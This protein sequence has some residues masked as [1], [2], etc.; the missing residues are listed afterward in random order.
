MF[1]HI[2]IMCITMSYQETD[3]EIRTQTHLVI[4]VHKHIKKQSSLL[5]PGIQRQWRSDRSDITTGS[6]SAR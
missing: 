1:T 6:D 5:L 4:D 3:R 2:M